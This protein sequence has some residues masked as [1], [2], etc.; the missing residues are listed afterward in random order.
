M[1]NYPKERNFHSSAAL[2]SE[3]RR[4]DLFDHMEICSDIDQSHS[5]KDNICDD[6]MKMREE[7]EIA[8]KFMNR[9]EINVDTSDSLSYDEAHRIKMFPILVIPDNCDQD[10][11]GDTVSTSA[12][13]SSSSPSFLL[14]AT[15]DLSEFLRKHEGHVVL[16]EEMTSMFR[17]LLQR[18]VQ[19][20]CSILGSNI[21]DEIDDEI[22]DVYQRIL[23]TEV[24][25]RSGA[26]ATL[27][28]FLPL[29]EMNDPIIVLD[30]ASPPTSISTARI[31]SPHESGNNEVLV[32]GDNENKLTQEVNRKSQLSTAHVLGSN[33]NQIEANCKMHENRNIV[34]PKSSNKSHNSK[35]CCECHSIDGNYSSL[36]SVAGK[37]ST[38]SIFE[39]NENVLKDASSVENSVITYCDSENNHSDI[40]VD[41]EKGVIDLPSNV[42]IDTN[43]DSYG[44]LA[45]IKE[46]YAADMILIILKYRNKD[47][48]QVGQAKFG[49]GLYETKR[50][51]SVTESDISYNDQPDSISTPFDC[52]EKISPD[53]LNEETQSSIESL[54]E[55]DFEDISQIDHDIEDFNDQMLARI[56][57]NYCTRSSKVAC[58]VS[59]IFEKNQL[60]SESNKDNLFVRKRRKATAH[61]DLR[62]YKNG[63]RATYLYDDIWYDCCLSRVNKA[64]RYCRITF[65]L[66]NC[67]IDRVPF[68]NISLL[69]NGNYSSLRSVAGKASTS[70][71]FEMNENVLKDASS[72]ENSVI[73]YCD[74]E[75]NHSDIIVDNEK[76]VIDLPSNVSIDTNCDS[77]GKLAQIKEVYAADMILIILKYRNKDIIQV[78]QAKFGNGLYETKRKRSVTESDI[79]YNDQPDSISTP[80]DCY[81]KISPDDL[82]EETQSSIESLS[83]F[84]FEDISQIDHDIEDFNDQ[85]LARINKNYCT[86]SSKVACSVS[87]IFEKNQLESES[88]KDNLFVR[89]RRKATAHI[90]LRPYKNGARATYLYDDIWYDCCLSR[91]NKAYR[92][93]RITFDLDN[94]FI[95][96]VP[97][98]NISLLENSSKKKSTKTRVQGVKL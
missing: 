44:K 61:I 51:R 45:Q 38:S 62:P 39:M 97:F 35:K 47:I 18:G 69:V 42:S 31:H 93:C 17:P 79:S 60:E 85:M 63:A 4:N 2:L 58:S 49:N 20:S 91:V 11:S 94:C 96:R 46:V 12:S 90:D 13:M 23:E 50:K 27:V 40:I 37:A 10:S 95:D 74:S 25:D 3:R 8:M 87:S 59:S 7:E 36:R 24:D 68:E 15:I 56:N 64:Y 55:F 48:I 78:G 92:Y 43:C 81:E 1:S 98:E 32:A 72:V 71:I 70:S 52:Y 66:D 54:S 88:N 77:Y 28:D 83:E 82:N 73:T 19:D 65:D 41:N 89:K 75:N 33:I 57:K 5:R 16:D 30:N 22:D 67:F 53:D 9:E 14:R 29:D 84:D 21:D 26:T 86:R 34:T 6:G 76:G 80:F